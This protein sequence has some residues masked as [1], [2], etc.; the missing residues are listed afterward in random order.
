MQISGNF[1]QYACRHDFV[2][3]V[4]VCVCV[5]VCMSVHRVCLC[6]R[7]CIR[8]TCTY[9]LNVQH[10]RMPGHC[11][12]I[13]KTPFITKK[14]V[15]NPHKLQSQKN[16][17][18]CIRVLARCRMHE[19]RKYCMKVKS[20]AYLDVFWFDTRN[21]FL[22]LFGPVWFQLGLTKEKLRFVMTI[23]SGCVHR[24]INMFIRGGPIQEGRWGQGAR[25]K[26][27]SDGLA[28]H[29]YVFVNPS[30]IAI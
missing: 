21:S 22:E 5:C 6:V 16:A 29:V 14:H 23:A 30:S 18:T 8:Y 10:A 12:T 1:E 11:S 28:W 25:P 26:G 27:L 15:K 2:Q 20:S 9:T 17:H 24:D 19:S 13:L 7:V 3:T 4:C